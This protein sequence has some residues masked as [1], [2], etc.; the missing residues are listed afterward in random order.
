M[1]GNRKVNQFLIKNTYKAIIIRPSFKY[2]F[3]LETIFQSA[4]NKVLHRKS[5]MRLISLLPICCLDS[6][7]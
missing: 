7:C 3:G 6:H 2:F 4:E 1:M 5:L